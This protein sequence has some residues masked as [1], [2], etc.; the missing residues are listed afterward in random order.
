M[1]KI[2]A[3]FKKN[4]KGALSGAI[5][6]PVS[7]VLLLKSSFTTLATIIAL[8]AMI[9]AGIIFK[10]IN[11]E[12]SGG[13][14]DLALLIMFLLASTVIVGGLAGA[15]AQKKRWWFKK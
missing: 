4:Y 11:P 5:I 12:T 15:Y 13:F 1:N 8:P 9:P 2:I 14:G 6:Y 3:F 10:L 7:M